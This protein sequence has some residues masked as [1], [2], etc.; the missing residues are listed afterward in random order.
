M[1]AMWIMLAFLSAALLGLYDASK[2]HSL[3]DNAVIPI[4]FL[5]TL[6]C[7]L[8]LAP[9]IL[10]SHTGHIAP[11][12]HFYVPALTPA[13]HRLIVLKS[14]IV[15]S[16][17]ILG[18]FAIK[19]LPL[20]IAGSV[21]ATRPV[22]T[23][24]GALIVF[25]ESLNLWQWA[26]VTLGAIS[27]FMMSRSGS[28]EGIRFSHNVWI[29]MLVGAALLGAASGLYDKYLMAPRSAGGAG[30]NRMGVQGWY[31]IYQCLMMGLVLIIVW[32]PRRGR[33]TPFR[34]R[35]SIVLISVFLTMADFVYFYALTDPDAMIS[36]VSMVRRGSVLVSFAIGALIFKEKNLR[37]KT[38]DLCFVLTSMACLWI[39]SD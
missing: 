37:S 21:N 6:F 2:K 18:Y 7:A 15:L 36:V 4:L 31:N 26:G 22:L 35:H 27:F 33:S 1:T 34:W 24:V 25:G 23:I 14:S 19:H 5:N 12:S 39:G 20:T 32:W 29:Y 3:R 30:V 13:E 16:S 10:L 28:K 11:G 9:F 8:L 17:W 38:I